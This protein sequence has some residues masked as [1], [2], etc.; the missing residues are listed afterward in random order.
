MNTEI[1]QQI[2]VALKNYMEVHKL[3]QSEVATVAGVN[4]AYIMQIRKDDFTIQSGGKTIEIADKYFSRIASYI[5]YSTEQLYWKTQPTPQMIAQLAYMNDAKDNGET[6]VIIGAT[7]SGKSYVCNLFK[8]KK[9]SEVFIITIGKQDTISDIIDKLIKALNVKDYIVRSKSGRLRIIQK[10]LQGMSEKG[11]EPTLIFDESEYMKQTSLCM[12]KELYDH[13]NS[14]AALIMIGTEQLVSNLNKMRKRNKDGIPQ[15]YRRIK[16]KIRYLPVIDTNYPLFL[17]K[18]DKTAA[19]WLQKNCDN[20]GELH[21]ALVPALR[22][23]ERVG[24]PV[25]EELIKLVLGI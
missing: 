10:E 13:L 15:L 2:A 18:V 9:P 23:S 14:W 7:G 11:L 25:T 19:R 16:Y 17:N 24:V 8:K 3:T 5:G 6:A 12:F 20:Y 4:A 1:K 22:E 21:D